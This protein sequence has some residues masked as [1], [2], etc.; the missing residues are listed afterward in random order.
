MMEDAWSAAVRAGAFELPGRV[1]RDQVLDDSFMYVVE[2][3]TGDEY[4]ASMIEDLE[5]PATKA[6]QQ[7]KDVYAAVSRVLK[8]DQQQKP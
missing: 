1:V 8:T 6:D 2:L 7:V 4:R 3:R 5:Q